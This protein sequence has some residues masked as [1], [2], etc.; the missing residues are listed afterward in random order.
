MDRVPEVMQWLVA[1]GYEVVEVI[2]DGSGK[3][4]NIRRNFP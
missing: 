4:Y 3:Y 2:K 1:Q